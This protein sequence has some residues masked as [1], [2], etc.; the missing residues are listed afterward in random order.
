MSKKARK[1]IK[2]GINYISK[3]DFDKAIEAFK[4]SL[5]IDPKDSEC[6]Y[7]LGACYTEKKECDKAIEALKHSLE[8]DPKD[9][10]CWYGLGACYSGKK[11]YDKAIE[12]FKRSLEINPKDSE[13]WHLL[14]ISYSRKKEYDK[15]IEAFKRS[16]EINPKDSECW[17]DLSFT[18]IDKENY[19]EAL[20]ALNKC[21]EIKPNFED[22]IELREL[23]KRREEQTTLIEGYD[24]LIEDIIKEEERKEREERIRDVA[25]ED[26]YIL[27]GKKALDSDMSLNGKLA[28]AHKKMSERIDKARKRMSEKERKAAKE[29]KYLP[30]DYAHKEVR[31]KEARKRMSEEKRKTEREVDES[32][33]KIR[34]GKCGLFDPETPE[35]KQ[36]R[37]EKR[38]ERV[39]IIRKTILDL[40]TKFTRLEVKEISEKCGFTVF[41]DGSSLIIET[42][43]DMI[44]NKEIYAEY[45]QSSESVS[46]NLQANIDEIDKLMEAYKDWEEKKVKKR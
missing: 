24:E 6:W 35:M 13:C 18:Y 36:E 37:L 21:L 25:K 9:S 34:G 27:S 28:I 39:G 40:G 22:A 2:K 32:I 19:Y 43:E 5:E 41:W 33:K 1:W 38:L 14:G 15:A 4:Y 29:V 8:I 30:I 10:E 26:K 7:L 23:L 44:K 16:L 3:D 42:I 17:I 31:V 45:F 12:A 11:E 20:N 46:F